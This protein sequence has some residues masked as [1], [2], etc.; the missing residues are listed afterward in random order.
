MAYLHQNHEGRV[1]KNQDLKK[2]IGFFLFKSDFLFF[3]FF[4]IWYIDIYI[5]V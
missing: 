4:L 1:E 3:L 5:D 2:K